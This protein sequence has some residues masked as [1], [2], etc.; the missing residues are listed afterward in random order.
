[1]LSGAFSPTE[2]PVKLLRAEDDLCIGFQHGVYLSDLDWLLQLL[3]ILSKDPSGCVRLEE[4][5]GA[6]LEVCTEGPHGD[7]KAVHIRGAN[8]RRISQ[9]ELECQQCNCGSGYYVNVCLWQR[10]KVLKPSRNQ[11]VVIIIGTAYDF[12]ASLVFA[13]TECNEVANWNR[14]FCVVLRRLTSTD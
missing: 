13:L 8:D 6:A 4:E 12:C 10:R 9:A 1:M 3:D 14:S 5:R 2:F 7:V 11:K